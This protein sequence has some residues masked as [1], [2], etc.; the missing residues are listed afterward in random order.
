[1]HLHMYRYRHTRLKLDSSALSQP[2]IEHDTTHRVLSFLCARPHA[3]RS[4]R[5]WRAHGVPRGQ[6][7]LVRYGARAAELCCVLE[8]HRRPRSHRQL[9]RARR[10]S[11]DNG[12]RAKPA[13]RWGKAECTYP[14]C[15]LS[16]PLEGATTW[17]RPGLPASGAD[18]GLRLTSVSAGG[19]GHAQALGRCSWAG[20]T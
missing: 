1:M 2:S 17:W 13:R 18:Q 8:L 6:S 3:A 11:E 5:K 4:V 16:L 12:R 14:G 20:V 15:Q 19:H 10:Q 9:G 7:A